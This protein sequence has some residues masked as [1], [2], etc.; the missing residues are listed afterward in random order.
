MRDLVRKLG[1]ARLVVPLV[2][3]IVAPTPAEAASPAAVLGIVPAKRVL[4]DEPA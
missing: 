3:T 2:M 1:I 4:E